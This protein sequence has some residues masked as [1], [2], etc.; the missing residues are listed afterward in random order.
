M[1]KIHTQVCYCSRRVQH[2]SILKYKEV[3]LH[4]RKRE[5]L[6]LCTKYLVSS[7]SPIP[8]IFSRKPLKGDGFLF[9]PKKTKLRHTVWRYIGCKTISNATKS[10]LICTTINSKWK[11]RMDKIF[12]TLNP[13]SYKKPTIIIFLIFN[14][15]VR[16]HL[17]KTCNFANLISITSFKRVATTRRLKHW[18]L[19]HFGNKWS[20][21]S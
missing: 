19:K 1:L 11:M 10:S 4:A 18:K 6:Y 20:T 7:T 12:K 13:Q 17:D 21:N 5:H 16:N 14:N 2:F 9:S 3:R 15:F 8:D